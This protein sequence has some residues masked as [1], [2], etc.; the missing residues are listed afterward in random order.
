MRRILI[1]KMVPPGEFE[2]Q[3]GNKPGVLLSLK[4]ASILD[5]F[6]RHCLLLVVKYC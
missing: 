3:L 1:E 4:T 2:S 6:G 5:Y